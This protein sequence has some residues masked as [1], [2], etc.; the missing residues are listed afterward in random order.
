MNPPPM[1]PAWW[2]LETSSGLAC[3]AKNGFDA[4]FH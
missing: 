4:V 3:L 2:V 1:L